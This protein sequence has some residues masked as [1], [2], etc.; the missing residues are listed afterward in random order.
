[1][2]LADV[3]RCMS[4]FQLLTHQRAHLSVGGRLANFPNYL[5]TWLAEAYVTDHLD[6]LSYLYDVETAARWTGFDLHNYAFDLSWV[7]LC[8]QPWKDSLLT[9]TFFV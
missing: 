1:M 5:Q 8:L 7:P 4:P 3:P 2:V 9:K 6:P